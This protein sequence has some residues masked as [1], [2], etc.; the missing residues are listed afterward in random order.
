MV[1]MEPFDY[2]IEKIKRHAAALPD[3]RFGTN[4][5]YSMQDIALSAFCVFFMQSPSFLSA[6]R[7]MQT[8]RGKSNLRT[9]F[10]VENIPTDNHIRK[11]LD[12]VEPET[13]FP[14]LDAVYETFCSQG[15]LEPFRCFENNLLIALDAT[16]F[17]SSEKIHCPNCSVKKSSK[18]STTYYHS[19]ITPVVVAPGI[20]AAVSLRPEF[21]KPQDG[22]EKQDCEINAA[23]RWL[24]SNAQRYGSQ[25]VTILGDDLYSRQP[26]CRQ[27][28]MRGLHFILVCKPDSHPTLYRWIEALEPETDLHRVERRIVENAKRETHIVRYAHSVPL[29]DGAD[30]LRVNWV[31]YT[32]MKKGKTLYHNTFVT[33]HSI[34]DQNA[35]EI[36]QAG[37]ARWKI[38]NENNNTL[39]TKGYHLEHNF[40]HGKQHLS[41]LLATMNILAF[42]L[43][44][45]LQ[46]LDN[47]Y[48][49]IRGKLGSRRTFFE[50]VR[51]LTHYECFASW[52]ALMD[53]M[54]RGLEIG[55]YDPG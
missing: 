3:P 42:L 12:S 2:I 26:F 37:R 7:S 35:L 36:A 31:E 47:R 55:P 18:G 43:H 49:L 25:P 28:L 22:S 15:L 41:S 34:N 54:M 38:E 39:K 4:T 29:A 16:W 45:L 46:E 5:Q 14:L 19:A 27:L 8:Q 17:H 50:H 23:K 52:R 21:V 32:V 1:G 24:E 9:L 33:D 51:A 20:K 13:L 30:A 6:Q 53:Y 11:V 40:G 48:L 10:Q 44:T